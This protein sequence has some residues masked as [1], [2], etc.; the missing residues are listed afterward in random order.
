MAKIVVCKC[1]VTREGTGQGLGPVQTNEGRTKG[2]QS[3][4]GDDTYRTGGTRARRA[5]RGHFF[6]SWPKSLG[7]P[8]QRRA[9]IEMSMHDEKKVM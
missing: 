6:R 9:E 3:R 5:S 8:E 2:N 4:L 1:R 7:R